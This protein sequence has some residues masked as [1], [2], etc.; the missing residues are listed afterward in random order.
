MNNN[1]IITIGRQFG[2]AGRHIGEELA[3]K[4]GIP[5]YNEE[6]ITKA[7]QKSGMAHHVLTEADETATN[8]LLYTLAMGSSFWGG[9]A[10]VAFDMP[11]NDKLFVTQSDIIK[12]EAE[13]GPAVFIGRCADYVL[14]EHPNTIKLFIYAPLEFR[15]QHVAELKGITPDKA[16]DLIIKTD[17]RRANY[18]NYYT[19]QKWGKLENFD[20]AVD[21]SRLGI[22]TTAEMLYQYVKFCEKMKAQQ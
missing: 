4:L 7:A 10:G 16:K 21:S 22:E 20:L 3:G 5:F 6:L 17:K 1:L 19:G 14:R 9:N 15:M 2:S 8:S 18:Y 13:K 12:E 11:L